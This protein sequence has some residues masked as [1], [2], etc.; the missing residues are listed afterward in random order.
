MIFES[1]EC[2]SGNSTSVLI[3][4]CIVKNSTQNRSDLIDISFHTTIV[5]PLPEIYLHIV[6]CYK[7][8]VYKKFPIDLF[9]DVCAWLNGKKQSFAMELFYEIR[10]PDALPIERK[11]IN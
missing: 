2:E 10:W 4:N 11:F 9:D 5:K 6:L 7:Y 1:F 8:Q 3:N